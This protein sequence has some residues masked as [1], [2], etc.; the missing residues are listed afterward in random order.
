[1]KFCPQSHSEEHPQNE[2]GSYYGDL[3]NFCPFCGLP[4]KTEKPKEYLK[5]RGIDLKLEEKEKPKLIRHPS[6]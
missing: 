1:M 5:T 6:L 3:F 4:L 2:Q